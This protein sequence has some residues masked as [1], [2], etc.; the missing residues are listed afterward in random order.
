MQ[1]HTFGS[2]CVCG[3]I[4]SCI[5]C[6]YWQCT[7]AGHTT[8]AAAGHRKEKTE[9]ELPPHLA[10]GHLAEETDNFFVW[11]NLEVGRVSNLSNLRHMSP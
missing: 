10:S 3:N 7:C 4:Y 11:S 5:Y 8:E 2:V 1:L 6:I 9:E